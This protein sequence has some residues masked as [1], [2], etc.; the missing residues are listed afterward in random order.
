M[1][2]LKRTKLI[3]PL[4]KRLRPRLRFRLKNCLKATN[5]DLNAWS[6]MWVCRL[7]RGSE[8]NKRPH[9]GMFH[10]SLYF[11][12][13]LMIWSG[14]VFAGF[15]K[16]FKAQLWSA[17]WHFVNS[18][19]YFPSA[20]TW[21]GGAGSSATRSWPSAASAGGRSFRT[22]IY[23]TPRHC[24]YIETKVLP[25]WRH[26]LVNLVWRWWSNPA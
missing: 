25:T 14:W 8:A 3:C 20:W 13:H 24:P 21:C 22:V 19:K 11:I 1:I 4:R 23:V 15:L 12:L 7:L 16:L 17:S 2:I 9:P 5:R 26:W 18:T 6:A 10:Q